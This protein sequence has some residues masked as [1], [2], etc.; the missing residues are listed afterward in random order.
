MICPELEKLEA[1]NIAIRTKARQP[2]LTDAQRAEFERQ[3]IE[4]IQKIK[5]H[6]ASGHDGNPCLGD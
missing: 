6:Q 2:G 5:D 4:M 1:E 3:E